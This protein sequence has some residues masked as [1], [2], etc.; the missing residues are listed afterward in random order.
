M[1]ATDALSGEVPVATPGEAALA[2]GAAP[3]E[4]NYA[5]ARRQLKLSPQEQFLYQTHLENLAEGGVPN[6]AGGLS[7]LFVSTHQ[8]GG[9][10][11]VV[12]NVW[13]GAIVEPREGLMR[14]MAVGLE[15]FPAYRSEAEAQ[16]RY[17]AMHEYMAADLAKA[18]QG[19]P[20]PTIGQDAAWWQGFESRFPKSYVDPEKAK[21]E[22]LAPQVFAPS[23]PKEHPPVGVQQGGFGRD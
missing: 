16:A 14:A 23:Y 20:M 1:P 10:T 5:A 2:S 11:Y 7:T 6:P 21:G 8:V 12:P 3:V 22:P 19:E 9:K 4:Q 18:R 13:D 17:G 15:K